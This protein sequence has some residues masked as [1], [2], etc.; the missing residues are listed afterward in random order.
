MLPIHSRPLGFL[1]IAKL[2]CLAMQVDNDEAVRFY[3][4]FGFEVSR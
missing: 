3:K 4:R 2:N 1:T